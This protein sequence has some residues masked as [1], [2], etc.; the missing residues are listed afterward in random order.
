MEL[1][2]SISVVIFVIGILLIVFAKIRQKR[3][4]S[5]SEKRIYQDTQELP[6]EILEAK[7]LHLYGKPDYIIQNT[8]GMIPVE[9]KTGKTPQREPYLNHIM[10]V[11][12]YCYLIEETYGKRPV[13]GI[14][15][16][17]DKEYKLQYT[18]A[19]KE[20]V[21]IA[22]KEILD[23]KRNGTEFTCKHENH[24]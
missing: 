3:F 11:M 24:N 10:Q 7:N 18:D 23:A 4:G 19:A 13:G 21:E 2:F 6:G 14:I 8:D 22:V 5:L 16:Y 17:P 15:K 9:V 12:A 1:A 20:S